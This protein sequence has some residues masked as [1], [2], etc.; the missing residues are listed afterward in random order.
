MRFIMKFAKSVME[1]EEG[2]NHLWI[3]LPAVLPSRTAKAAIRVEL[4]DGLYRSPNLN[5]YAED[6]SGNIVLDLS[7]VNDLLIEICT[8]EAVPCGEW[9][10]RVSLIFGEKGQTFVQELPLLIAPEDEIDALVIDEQVVARLKE[11]GLSREH[12]SS[13]GIEQEFVVYPPT[14]VEAR[15]NEFAFLARKY[16][17]DYGHK[18]TMR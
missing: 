6:E 10:I 13:T 17:V 18:Y 3:Q 8:Q 1:N 2:M 12:G 11:M 4:P 15:E 16:R 7:K 9:A 14:I 5:G